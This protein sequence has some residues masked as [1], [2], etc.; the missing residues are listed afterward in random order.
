M[1]ILG[2]FLAIAL[3]MFGLVTL[4][5][6]STIVSPTN[7]EPNLGYLAYGCIFIY[8]AIR[9]FIDTVKFNN[10]FNSNIK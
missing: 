6:V 10:W 8:C 9:I 5:Y 3:W 2:I 7:S 1:K 4:G